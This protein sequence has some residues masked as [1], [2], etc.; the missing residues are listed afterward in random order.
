MLAEHGG[1]GA[2]PPWPEADRQLLDPHRLLEAWGTG[3]LRARCAGT[4]RGWSQGR[5][6]L[7]TPRAGIR[8]WGSARRWVPAPAA[9]AGNAIPQSPPSGLPLPSFPPRNRPFTSVRLL[10]PSLNCGDG[11]QSSGSG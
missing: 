9:P 11:Q 8:P 3:Y 6:R 7:A 1:P 4:G 2:Q 10:R 5:G